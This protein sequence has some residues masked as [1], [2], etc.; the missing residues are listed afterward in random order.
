M[1]KVGVLVI[2]YGSRGTA[3]NDAF[4]RSDKYSVEL[5]IVDKNRN[6]FNIRK[7][8]KHV[9]IPDLDVKSIVKFA[10]KHKNKI[11]LELLGQKSQ[12]SLV[13]VMF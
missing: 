4:C 13:F 8:K 9:V 5:Y 6:P 2:C 12:S 3:I 7:A 11:A 10:D 1:E